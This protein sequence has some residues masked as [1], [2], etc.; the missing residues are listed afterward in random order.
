MKIRF[1]EAPKGGRDYKAGDEAEFVGRVEEGYAQK[2]IDR[3][4]AVDISPKIAESTAEEIEA[5]AAAEAARIEA[6]R[7]K[8]E[9]DKIKARGDIEID[10]DWAELPWHDLRSLA[11]SLSDD[12]VRSKDDATDVI[13]AELARRAG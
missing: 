2:Y 10:E 3:G 4:W 6:E 8:A 12:P 1:V 9:A 7:L 13:E 11:A 5:D